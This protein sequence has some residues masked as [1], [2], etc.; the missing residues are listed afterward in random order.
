MCCESLKNYAGPSGLEPETSCFE[1]CY[2]FCSVPNQVIGLYLIVVR[3]ILS[4]CSLEPISGA[5]GAGKVT[6]KK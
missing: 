5:S 6:I 3:L 4:A 2:Y 1:F